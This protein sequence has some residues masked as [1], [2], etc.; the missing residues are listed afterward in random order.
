MTKVQAVD[1]SLAIEVTGLVEQMGTVIPSNIS[2]G[3]FIQVAADNN[4][5]NEETLDGKN[6]THAT[7]IVVYQ[8][9]QYGPQPPST[10]HVGQ[11]KRRRPLHSPGPLYD[12]Q[13]CSMQGRRPVIK[14]YRGVVES[15]WFS[16]KSADLSSATVD[17]TIWAILRINPSRL[18]KT[19]IL[20]GATR[21]LVPSWSAFNAILYPGIPCSTNI[22]YCP[23]LDVSS[24]EFSTVYTVMK[25]A[26]QISQRV[27]QL[28]AVITF[29]LAIHVKAKEIQLKFPAEFSNTVLRL[30]SFHIALNFLSIIGKKHQSSGLEDLLIESGVYAA[31]STTALMNGRSYNRGVRTHKLCFEVFFCLL[32]RAFLVWYSQEEEGTSAVMAE[33]MTRTLAAC[34]AKVDARTRET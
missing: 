28:E 30:G 29:D 18:L 22:G 9:K 8:C 3:P 12:V 17:D 32:W 31:G 25:H 7:T 24:T 14:D 20:K 27:R 26:Q 21:Q 15:E 33:S 16:G 23:L 34:R 11:T 1:T 6:T 5:A 13:D 10:L 19:T 4:D 2:P